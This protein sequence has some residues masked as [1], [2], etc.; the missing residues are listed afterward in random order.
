MT[1][2]PLSEEGQ[3]VVALTG[4]VFARM[5]RKG[6]NAGPSPWVDKLK[7]SNALMNRP[8]LSVQEKKLDSLWAGYGHVDALKAQLGPTEGQEGSKQELCLISKQVCKHLHSMHGAQSCA[9]HPSRP[10][11]H[12]S[13]VTAPLLGCQSQP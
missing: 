7:Q 8:V 11:P 1:D 2:W 6:T 10:P 5:H 12:T 13:G 3:R 4:P 9:S